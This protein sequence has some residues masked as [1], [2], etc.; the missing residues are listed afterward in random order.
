MRN[1][2][3]AESSSSSNNNNS[4]IPTTS[5]NYRRPNKSQ[6]NINDTMEFPTL[7]AAGTE[8]TNTNDKM[9]NGAGEK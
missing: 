3:T 6:P 2:Q 5:V 7:D 8:N 9:S 4:A 1:R